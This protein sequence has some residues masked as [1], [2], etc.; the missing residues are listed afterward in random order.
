[1]AGLAAISTAASVVSATHSAFELTKKLKAPSLFSSLSDAR[2]YL[3]R[4]FVIREESL[5]LMERYQEALPHQFVHEWR[6]EYS[7]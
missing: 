2:A 7:E 4:A 3:D 6:I 5:K 1:M